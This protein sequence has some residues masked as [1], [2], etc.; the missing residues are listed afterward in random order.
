MRKTLIAAT[1]AVLGAGV[2]IAF[3]QPTLDTSP[4]RVWRNAPE[5]T[6]V[7][8]RPDAAA[9]KQ[10]EAATTRWKLTPAYEQEQPFVFNP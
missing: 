6:S 7:E 9:E 1:I 4:N 5:S 2:S 3:A 10:P 8:A